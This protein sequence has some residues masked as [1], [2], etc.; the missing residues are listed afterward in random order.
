MGISMTP[1]QRTAHGAN[2]LDSAGQPGV[3]IFEEI[4]ALANKH[5]AINLGQGFPDTEGPEEVR[6]IAIDS[7]MGGAN[8]YA[9]GS[10]TLR[11]REAISEHQNRFYSLKIDP[12]SEVVVTT[13]AT[14]AIMH[15]ATGFHRI[16]RRSS[17]FRAVLRLLCYHDRLDEC[18]R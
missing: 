4:T 1:W 17:N 7:I 13:G 12:L 15:D 2:L 18:A 16:R 5:N 3:T 6:Q 14:E 10:G 8:Q 9:P 11:L